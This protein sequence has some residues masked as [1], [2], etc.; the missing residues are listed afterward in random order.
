[1]TT[2][3]SV[4]LGTSALYR[5]ADCGVS[6][7]SDSVLVR[8]SYLGTKPLVASTPL[9]VSAAGGGGDDEGER[10]LYRSPAFRNR[11]YDRASLAYA[12]SAS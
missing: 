1:M 6:R 8:A 5:S 3:G 4:V 12:W 9:V 2:T 11:S 10:L 7:Y